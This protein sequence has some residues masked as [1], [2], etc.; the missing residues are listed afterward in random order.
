[1]PSPRSTGRSRRRS[2]TADRDT[3][4]LPGAGLSEA[5]TVA[6]SSSCSCACTRNAAL[7]PHFTPSSGRPIGESPRAGPAVRS[8]SKAACAAG[9]RRIHGAAASPSRARREDGT[10]KWRSPTDVL[11]E[12]SMSR[13]TACAPSARGC[14]H[15]TS[16]DG[17]VAAS[18]SAGASLQSRIRRTAATCVIVRRM[19]PP[20]RLRQSLA[21]TSSAS[22]PLGASSS[23]LR[24]I[25]AT[26]RSGCDAKP[27]PAPARAAPACQVAARMLRNSRR[28]CSRSRGVIAWGRTQGG[29]PMTT[30]KP[31]AAATSAK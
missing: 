16:S 14:L 29:L 17:Y 25:N 2:M 20:E 22:V 9:G 7:Q 26:A 19:P 4:A 6:E 8:R 21:G 23:R 24:S 12:T 1:M 11:T 28:N 3:D 15:A 30:S 13:A 31:P 18:K 10:A 5:T 27:T